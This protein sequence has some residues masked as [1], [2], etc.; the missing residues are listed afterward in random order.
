MAPSINRTAVI[1]NLTVF[2]GFAVLCVAIEAPMI[3]EDI[4]KRCQDAFMMNSIPIQGLSV[5]GRDVV[6]SGL[7][8]SEIMS[9]RAHFLVADLK[10]VRDVRTNVVH[11]MPT[12]AEENDLEPSAG[13][14]QREIQ[15]RIDRLLD[16]RQIGFRPDS[17][18]LTPEGQKVLDEV[19]KYLSDAPSLRC[20]I[21]GYDNELQDARQGVVWALLRALSTED[22]LIGRGIAEWRLSTHAVRAGEEAR[23]AAPFPGAQGRRSDRGVDLVVKAR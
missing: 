4:L 18:V 16:N 19:A 10:G 15:N 13:A 20:E 9:S 11:E 2:F 17:A 21:W 12:A 1:L 6:L 22:Y 3:Q 5:R 7:P 23:K 8:E 14:R